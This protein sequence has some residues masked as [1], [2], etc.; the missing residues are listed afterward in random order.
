MEGL[1]VPTYRNS[2]MRE[3]I[4][5][6]VHSERDRYIL[7]RHFIDKITFERLGEEL[8][9]SDRWVRKIAKRWEKELER[10]LPG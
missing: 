6:H 7:R 8:G 5:E 3:L 10:H 4:E 2:Q 1:A 9:L